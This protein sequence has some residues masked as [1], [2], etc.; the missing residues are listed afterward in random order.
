[1]AKI[2]SV[3]LINVPETIIVGD[4]INDITVKTT[5]V[6]HDIDLKLQMEYMLYLYVYEVH[7]KIDVPV[8]VSNWDESAVYSLTEDR[9]DDFLG[10][11]KVKVNASSKSEEI[12]SDIKL[13]L[14]LLY[15]CSSHYTKK[16]ETFA[17]L[18]PAVTTIG[19]WSKPY[20]ANLEF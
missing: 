16:L 17:V 7:G 19:K 3:E 15:T 8:L 5:V 13:K 12:I 2:S 6:F 20:S 10:E 9:K 1:M 11:L 14:G 4:N 18:V